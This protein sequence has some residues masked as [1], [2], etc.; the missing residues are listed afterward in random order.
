M[1]VVERPN[2]PDCDSGFRGFK[3]RQSPSYLL[4]AP[5]VES[6]RFGHPV[7]VQREDNLLRTYARKTLG[8]FF[9]WEQLL[10]SWARLVRH[11]IIRVI[12]GSRALWRS[13]AGKIPVLSP[14]T[15]M[16]GSTPSY[17]RLTINVL[18]PR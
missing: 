9:H 17:S 2:T 18:V 11:L 5:L 1:T 3:S 7:A 6:A 14:K 15:V 8:G 10:T 4:F 13:A 12:M 16:E